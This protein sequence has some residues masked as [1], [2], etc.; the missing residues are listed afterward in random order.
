MGDGGS[1]DGMGQ[2]PQETLPDLE[3]NGRP[4]IG[5]FSFLKGAIYLEGHLSVF[6]VCGFRS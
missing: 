3:H 1:L 2:A 6:A 4:L 5:G